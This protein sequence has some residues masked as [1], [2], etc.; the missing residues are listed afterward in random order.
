M[1][2][3][4]KEGF[5]IQPV[6]KDGGIEG[7]HIVLRLGSDPNVTSPEGRDRKKRQTAS[8][9]NKTG[10]SLTGDEDMFTWY[11]VCAPSPETRLHQHVRLIW[12]SPLLPPITWPALRTPAMSQSESGRCCCLF[13]SQ[14]IASVILKNPNYMR[15]YESCASGKL[16]IFLGP[17]VGKC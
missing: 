2:Q 3:L 4:S 14:F 5:S 6:E 16:L 8:S 12:T 7:A 13:F 17:L 9:A 1:I 11:E 15:S 10:E